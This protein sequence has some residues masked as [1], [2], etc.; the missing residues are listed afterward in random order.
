MGALAGR[1]VAVLEGRM[2]VELA[3][4]VRRHGGEP[5]SVPAVHEA[6][7][8]CSEEVSR[9]LD[10]LERSQIDL[11]IF[12]T[13]A[14]VRALI[15]ESERLARLPALIGG[16][17]RITVACRGPKPAAALAQIKVPVAVR[18]AEPFTS[19]EL[20]AVPGMDQLDRKAVLLVHYGEREGRL[21]EALRDRGAQLDEL[22]LYEWRLPEDLTPLRTLVG[23]ITAGRMDAVVFTSQVQA[24]H[25]FAVAGQMGLI[26]KL[27]DALNHSTVVASLAPTCAGALLALGVNPHVVPEHSKSGHLIVALARHFDPAAAENELNIAGA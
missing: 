11:A 6:P 10:R 7:L 17:T 3:N 13:G 25:L 12:L 26:E 27:R 18:A 1:R 16:L 2:R 22:C 14:G 24:R 20:L 5:C 9:L 21:A 8:D 4:L 23:E 19:T 15:A